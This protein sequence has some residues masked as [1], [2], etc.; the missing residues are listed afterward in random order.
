MKDKV[1]IM[2]IYQ[3]KI[4]TRLIVSLIILF[5]IF[6]YFAISETNWI[7]MVLSALVTLFIVYLFSSILYIINGTA[8]ELKCGCLYN[9]TIDI[10]K[11]RKVSTIYDYSVSPAAAVKKLFIY[12][13]ENESVAISPVDKKGF[14]NELS[15][16]NPAIEIE[17]E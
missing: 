9:R 6:L 16:I 2:K 12:Y 14:L 1:S 15:R 4:G 13:N 7:G 17:T 11:I 8:L 5:S 10:R 3:P